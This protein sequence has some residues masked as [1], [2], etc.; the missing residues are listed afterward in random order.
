MSL[1]LNLG[2]ANGQ[3]MAAP[4][5]LYPIAMSVFPVPDHAQTATSPQ[6]S[7]PVRIGFAI[8]LMS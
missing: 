6:I 8:F 3:T 7:H 4:D 2:Q 5:L 1:A